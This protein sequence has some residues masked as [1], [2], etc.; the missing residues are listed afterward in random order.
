MF[1][2]AK[3][4]VALPGSVSLLIAGLTL[5]CQPTENAAPSVASE[6]A[7]P[8]MTCPDRANVAAD[9]NP[10]VVTVRYLSAPALEGR[11]A[12]SQGEQCAMTF[13]AERLQGAG[14]RPGGPNG[15]FFEPVRSP[16]L[17]SSSYGRSLSST[18]L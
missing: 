14:L 7:R 10:T 18:T 16:F 5:G 4:R 13:I 15:G 17:Q 8:G 1:P 12:G 9:E 3:Q 6:L 2:K 11:S